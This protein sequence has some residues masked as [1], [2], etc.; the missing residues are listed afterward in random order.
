[1]SNVSANG[2]T[3]REATPKKRR[4]R[5]TKVDRIRANL[6]TR[7]TA[8]A[9][10]PPTPEDVQQ[11]HNALDDPGA[12]EEIPE[13]LSPTD[14]LDLDE[15]PAGGAP[16]DLGEAGVP[17]EE[18]PALKS[19]TLDRPNAQGWTMFHPG[20]AMRVAVLPYRRAKNDPPEYHYVHPDLQTELARHLRTAQAVLCS[21]PGG[22]VFLWLVLETDRSPYYCGYQKALQQGV[23]FL[24]DHYF[25]FILAAGKATK[26]EKVMVR[27]KTPDDAVPVLPTRSLGKLLREALGN[28]R[29]INSRNHPVY[30]QLACG[31][32]LQ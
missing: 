5:K 15:I 28:D 7:P 26:L 20:L 4:R 25:Q 6:A 27:P 30:V 2:Q 12:V 13:V 32:K 22:D 9:A 1:M 10:D 23:A 3:T 29:V 21:D 31:Q 17:L 11:L 14:A 8:T 24:R 16:T 18:D 19:V